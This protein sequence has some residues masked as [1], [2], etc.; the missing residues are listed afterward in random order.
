M[1]LVNTELTGLAV[2][3]LLRQV[4]ASVFASD[5]GLAS[6][7]GFCAAGWERTM[8]DDVFAEVIIVEGYITG[9]GQGENANGVTFLL[10]VSN[11]T[12]EPRNIALID[13]NLTSS[14]SCRGPL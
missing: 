9:A 13:K 11:R 8:S 5:S 1:R 12:I 4:S 2:G 14:Y 3:N 6:P 10:G 7:Q